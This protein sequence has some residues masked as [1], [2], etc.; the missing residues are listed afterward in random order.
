MGTRG[1]EELTLLL[2]QDYYTRVGFGHTIF[3]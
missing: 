3:I 1:S 2:L